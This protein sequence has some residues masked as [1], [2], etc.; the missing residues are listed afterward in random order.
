MAFIIPD[1]HIIWIISRTFFELRVIADLQVTLVLKCIYFYSATGSALNK[2]FCY[3]LCPS[4]SLGITFIE[5]LWDRLQKCQLQQ[6]LQSWRNSLRK[7]GAR[8]LQKRPK[9]LWRACQTC[10]WHL[11]GTQ[12]PH[13]SL[14]GIFTPPSVMFLYFSVSRSWISLQKKEK[15]KEHDIGFQNISPDIPSAPEF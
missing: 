10:L 15:R 14:S 6:I 5:H 8:F 12:Q 13:S 11:S 9:S 1:T 2:D 7:H 3:F 4:K